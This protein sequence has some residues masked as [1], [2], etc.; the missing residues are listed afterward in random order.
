MRRII[1]ESCIES[2]NIFVGSRNKN[3]N[4]GQKV[5]FNGRFDYTNPFLCPFP[6]CTHAIFLK[7]DLS[8]LINN[9]NNKTFPKIGVKIFLCSPL[10]YP[11]DHIINKSIISQFPMIDWT[12]LDSYKYYFTGHDLRKVKIIDRYEFVNNMIKL[13]L[14]YDDINY[15][16]L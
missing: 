9:L 15:K 4:S 8:F 6:E 11:D 2:G 7:N 14:S 12:V 16:K 13:G 1:K 5:L 10:Y 3:I